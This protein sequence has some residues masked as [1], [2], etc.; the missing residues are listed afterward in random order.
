MGSPC[1]SISCLSYWPE[2]R[3]FHYSCV[4]NFPI[5]VFGTYWTLTS[6]LGGYNILSST[7]KSLP[8]PLPMFKWTVWECVVV[9][10]V[11]LDS[12]KERVTKYMQV[13][14]IAIKTPQ[15]TR[16][17]STPCL[18]FPHNFQ[19]SRTLFSDLQFLHSVNSSSTWKNTIFLL[20]LKMLWKFFWSW[21]CLELVKKVRKKINQFSL[22]ICK[23]WF[24]G[25]LKNWFITYV[26]I[27]W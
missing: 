2:N 12:E 21:V 16:S 13:L 8:V 22:A 3:S 4:H 1:S 7:K 15:L 9:I 10:S 18:R 20:F 11:L 5:Y 27:E 24:K 14:S 17:D 19:N 23:I 6:L 26:N 25:Y